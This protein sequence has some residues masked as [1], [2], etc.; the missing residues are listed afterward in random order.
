MISKL[1]HWIDELGL[2]G[3]DGN[4][5]NRF[6]WTAE[7]LK[8]CDWLVDRL[9]EQ[10][11]TA[12]ID[13]A[14]NVIGRWNAGP[15]SAVLVGSHLDTVPDGGRFDGALGVLSG[16]EAI[17][18]LKAEG[19]QPHRPLWIAAFNDEE[20]AR[21][22]TSMFGST[23]FVGDDLTALSD[24]VG[25]DG[26]RLADAMRQRGYDFAKVPTAKSI[27]QVG[28]YLELHIEQGARMQSKALAT[29]VV[30]AIVG[31]RG[32]R[33]VL[34]GQT[35]HAGTTMMGDRRDALVGASRIVVALRNAAVAAGDV[36][37]NVGR[38]D[39]RPGGANVVPGEAVFSVDVRTANLDSFAALEKLVS[40]TVCDAAAAERL[41]AEIS[42]T[43]QHRP[44]RMDGRLQQ[45]LAQ[46]MASQELTW[47]T[48]TSGAGHDAQVL[49]EHVPTGMLFVPS[50]DGISHAPEEF[51]SPAQREPGVNVLTNILKTLLLN[52]ADTPL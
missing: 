36:T 51:T 35:N 24:R 13:A 43:Y 11:L 9:H 37:A 1:D 32:Y 28:C 12:E 34:H 8:A 4:A 48:M 47:A 42:C 20:G 29:A 14:G 16:L 6:A 2:I 44:T 46:E 21:F 40:D 5:V 15:G 27:D 45:M 7:L 41:T 52:D 50:Q 22:D 18:R 19:F 25:V 39:I 3:G 10:E 30:T 49:A 26:V 17:R 38:I 31:I 33:I 23:A